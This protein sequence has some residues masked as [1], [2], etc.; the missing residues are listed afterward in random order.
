[1]AVARDR[2]EVLHDM[3]VDF[4]W[5]MKVKMGF[6]QQHQER[7]KSRKFRVYSLF[8]TWMLAQVFILQPYS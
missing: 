5:E 2:Q 3:Q 8:S 7:K 6:M 4:E 1:M